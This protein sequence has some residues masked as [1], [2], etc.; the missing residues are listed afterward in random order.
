MNNRTNKLEKHIELYEIWK[1]ADFELVQ[2][3]RSTIDS[4]AW[5]RALS[6][7][8]VQAFLEE[9][10]GFIM[11]E[12][13]ERM[14]RKT[15][16]GPFF[17]IEM[18]G[19]RPRFVFGHFGDSKYCDELEDFRVKPDQKHT[20]LAEA[21]NDMFNSPSSSS[22]QVLASKFTKS[23]K[24]DRDFAFVCII[25]FVQVLRDGLYELDKFETSVKP[26]IELRY[27]GGF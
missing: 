17:Q 2:P 23:G 7:E 12:T 26:V 27:Q 15:Q 3:S 9:M 16:E 13:T 21:V 20:R 19:G 22:T 14:E 6:P 24:L 4:R 18:I 5:Q 11:N 1:D 10:M 25:A 8:N